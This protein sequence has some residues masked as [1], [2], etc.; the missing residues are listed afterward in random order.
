ML[1]IIVPTLNEAAAIESTLSAL[2]PL[3]QRDH[4]L[5]VADGGSADNTRE[6]ARPFA[7]LVIEAPRGRSAQMNAGA[8]AA[9]GDVLLFLHADSLLPPAAD[10]EILQQLATTQRCW[11]RFDV[12]LSGSAVMLRLVESMMNLRSRWSGI[13]TGDQTLF[14]ARALFEHVGGYPEIALMEDIALST[15][16]RRIAA[17][18]CLRPQ[19]ITS[20]RRWERDGVLRTILTMWRLR[21]AY[22]LGADPDR[23]AAHYYGKRH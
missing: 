15:T 23:L 21:L 10:V 17:P 20:A 9:R 18:A 22:R 16:L 14:V 1:S 19:V 5:I 8:A 2:Q 6:L 3:R 7:D 13:A 11:G 4:E 12:R